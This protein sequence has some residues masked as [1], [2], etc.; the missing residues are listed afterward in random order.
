MTKE[1]LKSPP[2]VILIGNGENMAT[3]VFF[4]FSLTHKITFKQEESKEAK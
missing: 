1:E 2:P 4:P 3:P